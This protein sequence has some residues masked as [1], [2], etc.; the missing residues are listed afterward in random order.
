MQHGIWLKQGADVGVRDLVE[1]AVAAEDAGWDG[2]FVSDTLP[3]PFPDPW[4]VLAGIASRTTDLTLGTWVTPLP[5]RDPWQVAQEVGTLD[6]LSGGRVILGAGLGNAEEYE[7]FGSEYV[8]RDLAARFDESLDVITGLWQGEPFSYDGDHFQLE[9]ATVEPLPVQR[10][11]VPI[12]TAG[13]WPRKNPISRGARWDGLMPV[14]ENYPDSFTESE[15]HEMMDYYRE[16]GG[17][18][19]VLVPIDYRNTPDGFLE[20]CEEAGVTWGLTTGYDGEGFSVG[21]AD[22]EAGPPT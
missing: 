12:L 14:T 4:V 13:F 3:T 17:D 8:P 15:L 2:V 9:D 1:H 5:R 20:I 19:D 7:P 21:L 22:I 18:G 16:L 6:Q 10:P 11:R